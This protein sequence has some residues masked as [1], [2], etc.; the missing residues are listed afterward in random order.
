MTVWMEEALNRQDAQLARRIRI[1]ARLVFYPLALLIILGGWHLLHDAKPAP[2]GVKWSGTTSQGQ[3]IH[4][5]IDQTGSLTHVDT[6]ILES[7]T[8]GT[9]VTMH[10]RPAQRRFVQR[11][12]DV[13]GYQPETHPTDSGKPAV[14]ETTFVAKL[15]ANPSGTIHAGD[16]LTTDQ[17][18]LLCNSGAVAFT[19]QRSA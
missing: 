2:L 5:W 16:A 15:G 14:G 11:G 12:Q 3:A 17:G 19:L 6:H 7:C 1:G 18:T 10:W 13:R 4:A 8:D 9:R